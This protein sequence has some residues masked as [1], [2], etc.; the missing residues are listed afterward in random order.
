MNVANSFYMD[1]SALA[2][3]YI[4]EKGNEL[5]DVILD[6]LSSNRIYFLNVGTGEV[7]SILFR[8]RN[9]GR[10]SPADF[11]LATANFDDEIVGAA[12]VTRVPV[13]SRLITRSLPLILTHSINSTDALVLKSA[14]ALARR[15]RRAADDLVL[16]TSD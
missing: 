16:V 7:Y 5:V 1:A 9:T 14:L 10:L 13:T 3:R 12:P 8:K 6:T 4:P 11:G 15:L 2:K